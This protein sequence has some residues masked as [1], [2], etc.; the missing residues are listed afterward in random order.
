[1]PPQPACMSVT[2]MTVIN[3]YLSVCVW[4]EHV[5]PLREKS[6]LWHNLWVDCSRPPLGLE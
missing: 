2:G 6:I 5:A 1:M 3:K 4:S